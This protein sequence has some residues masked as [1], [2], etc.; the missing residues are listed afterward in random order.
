MALLVGVPAGV[1]GVYRLADEAGCQI[2]TRL[3]VAAA[4]ELVPALK[5]AATSVSCVNVEVSAAEP[6]DMAA[7]LAGRRSAI[8]TAV[9]QA[10]STWVAVT[11]PARMLAIIDVSGSMLQKVPTAGNATRAQVTLEAARR[12][13]GLFEDSWAVACGPSPPT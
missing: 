10:L 5:V 4:P 7:A 1:F 13:L 6:A 11:L 9:D 3:N 2:Q 8:A 12:G